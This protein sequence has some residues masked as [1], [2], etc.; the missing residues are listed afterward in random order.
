M[1]L[2]KGG[3][4]NIKLLIC[5]I[6][7]IF[8]GLIFS[9]KFINF[10]KKS[11]KKLI[12]HYKISAG[13]PFRWEYEIEDEGIVQFVESYVVKNENTGGKVGAPIY[14]DYVFK[15]LKKGETSIVFKY[16]NFTEEI[17]SGREVHKVIVDDDLN[18]TLVE[19]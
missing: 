8:C 9:F 13:I 7:V 3:F 17:V 11:S 10:D 15:G 5:F 6:F 16:V 19:D 18:I 1:Y 2:Y 14:T 4:M 12:L